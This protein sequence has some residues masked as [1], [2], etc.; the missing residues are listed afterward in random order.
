[1]EIVYYLCISR[2]M[3]PAYCPVALVLEFLQSRFSEGVTPATHK[4]YVAAISANH[5]YIDGVS[6]GRH[7]LV[8]F[9]QGSQGLRPFRPARV[10][11]WD[12]SI[13]LQGLSGHLFEPLE[14][15]TEKIL[16]LKT[17]LLLAL[18]SL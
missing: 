2:D 18:S 15:V 9:L 10:P 3:D 16:T 12:L 8:Q 17:I 11:S 7:P 6:V 4:V 5:T 13:V 14:T 1:M